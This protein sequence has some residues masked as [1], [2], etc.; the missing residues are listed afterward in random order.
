MI[1]AG[2]NSPCHRDTPEEPLSSAASTPN[3]YPPT[4]SRTPTRKEQGRKTYHWSLSQDELAVVVRYQ[5]ENGLRTLNN[6]LQHLLQNYEEDRARF[7][8]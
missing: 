2:P 7:A 3:P 4:M 8:R 6:A 5:Q 1:E